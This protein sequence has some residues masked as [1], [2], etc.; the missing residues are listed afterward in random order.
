M[1]EQSRSGKFILLKGASS[2]GKSTL[3]KALQ[4]Q[5]DEP[6]LRFSFDL[7]LFETDV[8]PKQFIQRQPTAYT[9]LRPQ[10]VEG[11][12]KCLPAL[13]SAGNN[14]IIDYV[15]EHKQEFY[16][17]VELL[18][19]FDVFFVGLHCPLAE[20]ERREQARGDRR[21]GDARRDWETVHS[22]SRY[23]FDIDSS[24]PVE[25]NTRAIIKAWQS[26]PT[27]GVFQTTRLPESDQT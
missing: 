3:G 27:G 2:S 19:P 21:V 17:L 1:S 6:F 15:L 25:Q 26:R 22:F 4:Q 24:Q 8:L 14:L 10:W 9:Q 23:D 12:F 5:L 13:A 11:Y 16:R 18:Q 20:L 7:F